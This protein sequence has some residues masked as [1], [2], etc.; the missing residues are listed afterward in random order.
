VSTA[1][2][3]PPEAKTRR[4]TNGPRDHDTPG[5]GNSKTDAAHLLRM[6]GLNDLD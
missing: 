4:E 2:E 3:N 6:L 1:P 5:T